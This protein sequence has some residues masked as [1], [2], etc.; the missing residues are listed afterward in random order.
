[1]I[2][3]KRLNKLEAN[4]TSEAAGDDTDVTEEEESSDE[5][6]EEQKKKSKVAKIFMGVFSNEH[7]KDIQLVFLCLF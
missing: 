2:K 3:G 6:D 7:S 4:F 5:T 1:M